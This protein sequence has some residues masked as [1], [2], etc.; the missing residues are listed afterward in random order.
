MCAVV[1][2]GKNGVKSTR[3]GFNSRPHTEA[4]IRCRRMSRETA[5]LPWRHGPVYMVVLG[6]KP[7]AVRKAAEGGGPHRRVERSGDREPVRGRT[8]LLCGP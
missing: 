6:T 3:R 8:R 7:V 4:R 2:I 5:V 1:Q